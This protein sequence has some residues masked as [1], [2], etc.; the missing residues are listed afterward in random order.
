MAT[1][2]G[3]SQEFLRKSP[4]PALCGLDG[5][6]RD[7]V[8]ELLEAEVL[9]MDT[10]DNSPRGQIASNQPAVRV[11]RGVSPRRTSPIARRSVANASLASGR[12]APSPAAH[13]S[14]PSGAEAA[15]QA[16]ERARA[17]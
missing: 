11:P 14:R 15:G 1:D 4:G 5:R 12:R 3:E 17:P 9:P 7:L 10:V 6:E 2:F 13:G 16:Q 8:D